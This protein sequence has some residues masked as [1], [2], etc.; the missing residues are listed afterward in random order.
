MDSRLVSA[1]GGQVPSQN[2]TYTALKNHL[3]KILVNFILFREIAEVLNCAVPAR[4]Y[5]KN[6]DIYIKQKTRETGQI[7]ISNSGKKNRTFRN[8]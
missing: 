6:N 3:I 7:L 4:L 1:A 2:S 5:N 8:S